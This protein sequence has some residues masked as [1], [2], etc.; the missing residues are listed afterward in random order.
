MLTLNNIVSELRTFATSHLQIND[1]RFGDIP[2]I[3]ET[4]PIYPSLFCEL[5][6]TSSEFNEQTDSYFVDF[7]ILDK[8]NFKNEQAS[9]LESL[10]DTKLIANDIIAY[11]KKHDFGQAFKIDLPISME[12]LVLTTEDSACGWHFTVHITLGQGVNAC[13]IPLASVPS[14]PPSQYVR[15]VNQNGDT[16]ASLRPPATYTVTELTSILQNLGTPITTIVQDIPQ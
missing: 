12:S 11:L 16:L 15:I 6:P 7:L 4:S 8:P 10:S 14:P 2:E 9:T 1:F 13:E 5:N 3:G